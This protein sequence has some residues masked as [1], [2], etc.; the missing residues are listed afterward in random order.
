MGEEDEREGSDTP[1][2]V[3]VYVGVVVP[4]PPLG[5]DLGAEGLKKGGS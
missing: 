1:E 2:K 3:L 5:Y 4:P